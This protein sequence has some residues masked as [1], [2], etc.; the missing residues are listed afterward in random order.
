[1][2]DKFN[3]LSQVEATT[4][5]KK[6]AIYALMSQGK[7]PRPYRLTERAVGWKQSEIEEWMAS[8]EAA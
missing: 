2:S 3:R 4:G 7:F 5:L 6:S 8:R 1:M